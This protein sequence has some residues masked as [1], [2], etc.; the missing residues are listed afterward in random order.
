MGQAS[1]A[2]RSA[3]GSFVS[4]QTLQAEGADLL[5]VGRL[6]GF[7]EVDGGLVGDQLGGNVG[8]RLAV[9]LH[10]HAAG[11]G[12]E[13]D[14]GPGQVPL[15]EDAFDLL[16]APLVDD[17]E[18]A[19]LGLAE[20]DLVA[21]HVGRALRHLVQL[22]L[23][24][25]AGAGRGLAGRA[26]QAGGAH[27]LDARHGAGGQQLQA[28]FAHQLF[29]ERIAHLHRAAL[30]VGRFLGQI[31]RGERRPGQAVAPGGRA[32]VKDRVAD[33]LGGAA[34]DLFVPED[35]QAKDINQRVAF[36]GLSK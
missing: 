16:L 5:E 23:D 21:A 32:H 26:G 6:A 17:D 29:H 1:R 18:H 25:G 10:H 3:I 30:L 13:A 2:L 33:A 15:V 14:L 24:A 12:D 35:A 34:G 7:A 22:D 4:R 36:V 19:L 9:M 27:V 8:H 11:V 31:L 28:G 20:H